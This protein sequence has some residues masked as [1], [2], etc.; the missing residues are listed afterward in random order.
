MYVAVTRARF[1]L[2]LSCSKKRKRFGQ[3]ESMGPSQFLQELGGE[4]VTWVDKEPDSVE[5]HEEVASHMEA[6]RKRLGLA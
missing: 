1:Y 6:M 4:F 2:T 3:T 5:A